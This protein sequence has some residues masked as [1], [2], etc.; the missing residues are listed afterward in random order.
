MRKV[1]VKFC[2]ERRKEFCMKT[3][4]WK[5][6]ESMKVS[7]EAIFPEGGET[8]MRMFKDSQFLIE[9]YPEVEICST[10][11]DNNVL[12]FEYIDGVELEEVIYNA[13]LKEDKIEFSNI[14]KSFSEIMESV[15]DNH[16]EFQTTSEFEQIFGKGTCFN[17]LPALKKS[18]YDMIPG[19]IIIRKGKPVLIDYEWTM[20]FPMPIDLLKYHALR[21]LYI[22]YEELEAFFPMDDVIKEMGILVERKYLEDAYW[23]FLEYVSGNSNKYNFASMKHACLQKI[24][25]F[26]QYKSSYAIIEKGWREASQANALLNQKMQQLSQEKDIQIQRLSLELEQEKEN[27]R[28]HAKQIE[29]AVQEQAHQSEMWRIAYESVINS[30]T[31]HIA[32][33]LKRIIGRK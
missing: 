15:P 12:W 14:L 4:I 28:I 18:N 25:D 23:K 20:E 19:N 6:G 3:V 13:A 32:N 17:G 27:H 21:E 5:D 22:H 30:R 10:K 29:D 1:L 9:I 26:D 31:W 7:K 2:D 8:L 11:L 24:Y 33:K 16:T